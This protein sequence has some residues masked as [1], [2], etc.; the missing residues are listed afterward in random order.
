MMIKQFPLHEDDKKALMKIRRYLIGFRKTNGW[1]QPQLSQMINGTDGGTWNLE[2]D[3]NWQWRM[4]RLQ[5]WTVPFGLRL[6][7]RLCFPDDPDLEARVHGNPVVAPMYAMSK[8]TGDWRQW[9]RFYVAQA[10]SQARKELDISAE[11]MGKFLGVTAKAVRAWEASADE[12]ML[13]KVLR[14]AR[15]LSGHISFELVEEDVEV[16]N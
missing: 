10:L 15:L 9:Q 5:D 8:G 6:E 7:V 16:Q 13:A 12:V 3:E 2:S 14:Y 4:S 1:T 11:V